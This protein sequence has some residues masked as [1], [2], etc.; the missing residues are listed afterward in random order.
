MGQTHFWLS[1]STTAPEVEL[2]DWIGLRRI[3]EIVYS[4]YACVCLYEVR[5]GSCSRVLSISRKET[6]IFQASR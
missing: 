3:S 6:P 5:A 4:C 1:Y 2:L